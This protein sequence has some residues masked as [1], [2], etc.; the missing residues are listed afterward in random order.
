M[1]YFFL[2]LPKKSIKSMIQGTIII[3]NMAGEYKMKKGFFV[4][5]SILAAAAAYV[6]TSQAGLDATKVKVDTMQIGD[7]K[8]SLTLTGELVPANESDITAVSGVVS[9]VY[10]QAGD[11]VD[12]GDVLFSYDTAEAER[13]LASAEKVLADLKNRQAEEQAQSAYAGT[14]ALSEYAQNA[15][16]L[17][18]SS[19]YELTHFNNEI[20]SW[21]AAA[22]TDRLVASV[23]GDLESLI[24]S[25]LPEIKDVLSQNDIVIPEE[26]ADE[27]Q[28]VDGEASLSEQI[29]TAQ[30]NVD[31]LKE[32][33]DSLRVKSAINGRVLEV[34][35]K[36][37]ETVSAG[38]TAVVVADTEDMEVKST[39]SSKDVKSLS[40]GMAAEIHSV[41]G[42][43]TVAG[44]ITA[45]GQRVIDASVL[46]SENMTDLVVSPQEALNELPGSSVD[47]DILVA[48]K[49]GVPVISLDCLT[50]DGSVFV[51]GGDGRVR[52]RKVETGLQDDYNVE[53]TDG[54]EFGDRLVLNPAS[55]LEEGQKVR[56]DD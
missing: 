20:T 40:V 46:G 18:Q 28:I 45:I 14:S 55:D 43:K 36:K 50:G 39:V 30:V 41:D 17:A 21:L 48:Q 16:S 29:G 35:V 3:S 26:A 51:V 22:L 27:L 37:G 56:V 8:I 52:K 12:A 24:Q 31:T 49:E 11:S 6:V 15:L 34:G 10:V 23:G 44:K 47:L 4:F 54:I 13:Q 32:K 42:K 5:A 38:S 2:N 33:L 9:E 7:I 53:V 1:Q 25:Y 19:G